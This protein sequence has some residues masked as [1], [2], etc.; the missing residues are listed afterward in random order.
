MVGYVGWSQN[1]QSTLGKMEG[2]LLKSTNDVNLIISDQGAIDMN[3][4]TGDENLFNDL[5]SGDLIQITHDEV[6]ESYP[7]QTSIYSCE[8]IESGSTEDIP[9]DTLDGQELRS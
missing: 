4:Q 2:T 5:K 1:S 8:L 7:A 3:N 6:A 9:Q